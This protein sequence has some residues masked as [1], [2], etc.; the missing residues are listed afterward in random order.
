MIISYIECSTE[1]TENYELGPNPG[2]ETA[3]RLS[4]LLSGGS[5]SLVLVVDLNLRRLDQLLTSVNV[6]RL[7]PPWIVF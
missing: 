3:H 7:G 2:Q 4:H 5:M 1:T 6:L